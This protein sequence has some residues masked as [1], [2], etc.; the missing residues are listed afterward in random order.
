ME[1]KYV[2]FFIRYS[3]YDNK[4]RAVSHGLVDVNG[5]KGCKVLAHVNA[6]SQMIV[7]ME[8]IMRTMQK[9]IHIQAGE[10]HNNSFF[11][12]TFQRNITYARFVLHVFAVPC[13]QNIMCLG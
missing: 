7:E 10:H 13:S 5:R 8:F 1:E 6:R 3:L 2:D 4:Q 11:H 12:S 9:N